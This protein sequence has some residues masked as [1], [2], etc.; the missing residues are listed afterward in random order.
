MEEGP[1]V[2]LAAAMLMDPDAEKVIYQVILTSIFDKNII[3]E[4]QPAQ[5][6]E[7]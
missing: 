6:I 1:L 7:E 4:H 5:R 2:S 3:L